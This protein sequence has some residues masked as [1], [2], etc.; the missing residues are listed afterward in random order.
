M[1]S[2][3]EKSVAR[4]RRRNTSQAGA[5]ENRFETENREFFQRVHQAYLALARREERVVT[6][7]ARRPISV[8]H[9]EIVTAV[10][11]RLLPKKSSAVSR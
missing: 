7:D 9:R 4:A 11:K 6:I 1:D 8:V 5:D 10:E 3:V 2:N